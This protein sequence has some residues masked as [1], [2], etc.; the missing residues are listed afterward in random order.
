MTLGISR[1]YI[2]AFEKRDYSCPPPA[3]E[4]VEQ[5][6]TALNFPVAWFYQDVIEMKP[7]RYFSW[8]SGSQILDAQVENAK[9][10]KIHQT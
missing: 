9:K 8:T 7:P 1:D 2:R 4:L 3:P 10:F 5:I 6:A